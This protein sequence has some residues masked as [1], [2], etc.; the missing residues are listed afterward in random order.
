MLSFCKEVS[1][2]GEGSTTVG[3]RKGFGEETTRKEIIWNTE[4]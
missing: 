4:A 2:M 1:E 3:R